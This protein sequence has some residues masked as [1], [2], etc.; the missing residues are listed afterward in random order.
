VQA[1]EAMRQDVALKEGV[2][3]VLD[4]PG[5]LGAGAGLGVGDEA[6]RM[7]L[8]QAVQRGLLGAVALVVERSAIGYPTGLLR[9]GLRALLA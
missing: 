8:H 9:R 3:L 1:Q 7:L 2:E 4:E 6:G 5:Q